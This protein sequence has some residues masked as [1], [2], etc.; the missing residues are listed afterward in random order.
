M[1]AEEH[2]SAQRP[3]C[4]AGINVDTTYS[5]SVPFS[6]TPFKVQKVE[7]SSLA[8]DVNDDVTKMT[9]DLRNIYA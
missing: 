5:I 1:Y 8:D 4:G 2:R 9:E 7:N 6:R 3:F